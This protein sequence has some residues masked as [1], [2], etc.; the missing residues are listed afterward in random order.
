ME[1]AMIWERNIAWITSQRG[2]E[3]RENEAVWGKRGEGLTERSW[4]AWY[5]VV[6][7]YPFRAAS[8][9]P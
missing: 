6:S 9:K 3:E 1:E 5:A 8:Q 7:C 2:G 4:Y